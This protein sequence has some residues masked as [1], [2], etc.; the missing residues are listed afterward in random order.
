MPD[1]RKALEQGFEAARKAD[2]AKK[3]IDEVFNDLKT[4]VLSG[5]GNKVLIERGQIRDDSLPAT[6]REVLTFGGAP[7]PGYSAIV[8]FNPSAKKKLVELA[9]WEVDKAGYPCTVT[10]SKQAH[11]CENKEALI[12]CLSDLLKDPVVGEKIYTLT[13]LEPTRTE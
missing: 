6:F 12:N 10:W 2:I 13:K 1:F 7:A 3:E 9:R 8:A 5:T 11:V 4:Q